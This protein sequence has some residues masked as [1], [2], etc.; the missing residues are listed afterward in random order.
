MRVMMLTPDTAIDRRILQEA[1]T[2]V[3]A[4]AEVLVVAMQPS[5]QRFPE[6][7]LLNEI[8]VQR[9]SF[10]GTDRRVLPWV[11]VRDAIARRLHAWVT[12][13]QSPLERVNVAATAR[14][15]KADR[16]DGSTEPTLVPA[17]RYL[18]RVGQEILR[19]LGQVLAGSWSITKCTARVLLLPARLNALMVIALGQGV[20]W[21]GYL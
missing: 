2:L 6:H 14:I 7:E 3:D 15:H 17:G 19:Q 1:A 21:I 11:P 12:W 13:A 10:D 20:C 9:F 18:Q 4:W 5:D 16:V 8:K